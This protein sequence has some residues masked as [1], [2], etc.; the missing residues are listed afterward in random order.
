MSGVGLF[1]D[2]LVCGDMFLERKIR[3]KWCGFL[4]VCVVVFC[5]DVGAQYNLGG[6]SQSLSSN[7]VIEFFESPAKSLSGTRQFLDAVALRVLMGMGYQPR[8]ELQGGNSLLGQ[9]GV[10]ETRMYVAPAQ[11]R[12]LEKVIGLASVRGISGGFDV[13]LFAEPDSLGATRASSDVTHI[14]RQMQLMA[15]KL[16]QDS[17]NQKPELGYEMIRLGHME[18]DRAVLLLKALGYNTMSLE[19]P[20]AVV[21]RSATG[22]SISN[23]GVGQSDNLPMVIDVG[24]ASKTS[25]MD[26]PATRTTAVATRPSAGGRGG[27]SGAPEL[28]GTYLHSTTAGAPEERLL[29]V[30]DKNDP[31]SLEK[32]VNVIQ[33]QIDVAAQQIVIEALVI[34]LN[35]NTLRDLGVEFSGSQ[36]NVETSFERASNGSDLPF[37][38]LFSRNGFTDFLSFKGKLEA[39]AQSGKAEVLSSPSVLVLN[40]RQARIQVG[41]QVPVVRSTTTASST[42]SS[43]E[44]FPIGIVLNLRPRISPGGEEVTMQIE[45]IISSISESSNQSA[46]GS[47]QVAFAPVVDN[48]TVET[49]VRVAEGTPFIIGGLLSTSK[50]DRRVGLPFLSSIPLLGRLVS[51]EQVDREQREVIV[52]ITPHIVPLEDRSFSYLIPKD[53]D[54]F[55]RFDTHLF[56]N[57]YRVRDDDVWD[58][59]FIKENEELKT[60]VNRVTEHVNMDLTF[61]RQ[62][63]FFSILEGRVAGE[64]VLVRRMIY[65]IIGKLKFEQ[66]ID[67][68]KVLYFV[69][70]SSED[71]SQLFDQRFLNGISTPAMEKSEYVSTLTFRLG[72]EAR[73]GLVFTVPLCVA[74]D[75]VVAVSQQESLLW[76]LNP[77]DEQGHPEQWTI[78][79]GTQKDLDRLRRVLILKQ[80]LKLNENVPLT[81][82]A[83]RPGVQILF[84]SRED[85]KNRYHVIDQ[86]VAKL[87]Y[88]TNF[89]Y[90]SSERSFNQM[91]KRVN[92]I[93]GPG[94]SK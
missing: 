71:Q 22:S 89:Y 13:A 88:E 32:L 26:V 46:G 63:P 57:G 77:Y 37:T 60:L 8:P 18:A 45:T 61:R 1:H 84:P 65:E 5:S 66:E 9:G 35:T 51:R 33:T 17:K 83:F 39:L 27:I 36:K 20:T 91:V 10:S 6:D 15:A 93:L 76:N 28:G 82:E 14:K 87:F 38:F 79:L 49:F 73:G 21:G 43:V 23:A 86:E 42:S 4:V 54:L 69:A 90:Q 80:L 56:R 24:K 29:L 11:G 64:D 19:V 12:N 59:N 31:E 2:L 74:R 92:D 52:V 62:E 41:Q 75:T 50:S 16:Q 30:Y 34:E 94:G 68:S 3:M 55:N 48:R 7:S 40:D 58:L 67:P 70:P 72:Q 44:Y 85:M 25:L 47:N 81:I 78:M 53:S